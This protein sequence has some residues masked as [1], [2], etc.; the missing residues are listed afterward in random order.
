M[1]D[2]LKKFLS[3]KASG[4]QRAIA[5]NLD[6]LSEEDQKK[7]HRA[8]TDSSDVPAHEGGAEY[9]YSLA[10]VANPMK[11]PHCAAPAELRYA[12][13][14]YAT[15]NAPRRMMAPAGYF[16]TRC[17]TVVVDEDLLRRGVS[18]GFTYRGV[19]GIECEDKKKGGPFRT[20]NGKETIVFF[21]E[22]EGTMDLL[23]KDTLKPPPQS[24][25]PTSKQKSLKAARRKEMAR[26]SRRQNRRK[27]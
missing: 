27:R 25:A 12:E 11:C 23:T 24:P 9:G 26:Q 17:P 2:L 18:Q 7:V 13:F 4:A 15:Q 14:I 5:A 19:I 16:C 1:S 10:N 8:M 22:V 21:D 20:W 6:G 3:G